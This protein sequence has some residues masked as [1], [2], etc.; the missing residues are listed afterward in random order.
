M[1]SRFL[2][3]LTLL[4]SINSFGQVGIN[5]KS[6]NASLEIK[7]SSTNSNTYKDGF[8]P[9]KLSKQDLA[10][11]N[12]NTYGNPQIGTIVYVS[13]IT[14]TAGSQPSLSQVS[15]I[16]IVGYYYF[17]GNL[18]QKLPGT[19]GGDNTNDSWVNNATNS[20]VELS[21]NSNGTTSRD[22]GTEVVITDA[23]NLGVG[24]VSP[25]N[26]LHVKST[27]NPIKIEGL[28]NGTFGDNII[29]VNSD[30]EIKKIPSLDA[31]GMPTPAIFKLDADISNF[32]DGVSAG[33][34]KNIPMSL[35][36]N[37][38]PNL[39]YNSITGSISIPPGVYQ[40]SMIYE[41]DYPSANTCTLSSYIVDFPFGAAT[42]RIHS[43]A[44]HNSGQLSNH[45]GTISYSTVINTTRDWSIHLGRGQSGNCTN[46][47]ILR[48]NSTHLIL[49]RMGS[50]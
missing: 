35:V 20:R 17:D 42:T 36:K 37:S 5:T 22:A 45:G 18:W 4:I 49:L 7:K 46:G 28:S 19:T 44:T 24:V 11:K 21:T 47:L 6:P 23:G 48:K 1:N 41:G 30:G 38:I 43:T 34:T 8:L 3:I 32:L 31:L 39:T 26:K 50:A 29:G 27:N 15:N 16:N 10:L 25:T 33:S 9:P 2:S 12:L 13:D 14:F 40:I